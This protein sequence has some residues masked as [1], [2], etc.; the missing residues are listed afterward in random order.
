MPLD[1][2]SV[3]LY[4]VGFFLL[5]LLCWI[6]IRPIK[7]ILRLGVTAL[8][9]GGAIALWNLV[10]KGIELSLNLNP[11]TAVFAGVLGVPG[12]ILTGIL[13]RIL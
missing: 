8:L 3:F 9:G 13:S 12:M 11:L 5:Y 6:F 7:W 1:T 4:I 10:G 2:G